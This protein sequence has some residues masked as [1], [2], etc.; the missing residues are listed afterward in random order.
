MSITQIIFDCDGV[1]IDSEWLIAEVESELRTQFGCPITPEEYTRRFVG[2][3]LKSREYVDSLDG[4]PSN[5][6]ELCKV[7]V[8]E[9]L[10]TRLTAIPGVIEFLDNL[11]L[12]KAVASSSSS[13]ELEFMLGIAGLY[14][15]FRGRIFSVTMVEHPKPAPD[16]YLLTARE[17]GHD[18]ASC[19]VIEDSIIGTT[20]AHAAG[21]KVIGFTGASHA[22]N[23][24][25]AS[26]KQAGAEAVF[27]NF[28]ELPDLL[29]TLGVP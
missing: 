9:A 22:H 5:Y 20:A 23:N 14:E 25:A 16:V 19:L 4:L 3:S 12:D 13:S 10:R 7:R 8:D 28:A 15:R 6:R 11:K 18:P 17:T 29:N 2:L 1:L 26:L 24:L 27:S 21:M